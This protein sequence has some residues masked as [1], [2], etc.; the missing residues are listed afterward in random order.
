MK[1]VMRPEGGV[2]VKL[3]LDDLEKIIHKL[4]PILVVKN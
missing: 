1:S 3:W 2:P 4:D